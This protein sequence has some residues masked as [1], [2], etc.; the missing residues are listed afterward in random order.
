[1]STTRTS[2]S[3]RR[4]R[5]DSPWRTLGA[6]AALSSGRGKTADEDPPAAP[7]T[8]R[9][10]KVIRAWQAI[11]LLTFIA[12]VT[13][14]VTWTTVRI[15]TAAF[16]AKPGHPDAAGPLAY[17]APRVAGSLP[18]RDGAV[19]DAA[20]RAI[21]AEFK[22]RFIGAGLAKDERGIHVVR[23]AG[24]Y[25]EPGHIDPATGHPA[26]V[27][28]LGLSAAEPLRS[29]PATTISRLM[30]GL[31]GPGSLVGPWPALAGPRRGVAECTVAEL[32]QTP[33]AVC[34]WATASTAGAVISPVRDTSVAALARIMVAMR[35]NLEP[36]ATRPAPTRHATTKRA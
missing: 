28:Y 18:L 36:R 6:R 9:P 19:S 2:S 4:A 30:T 8:A 34:G 32:G 29:P 17:P 12:I 25:G 27:M 16:A 14:A 10:A 11:A 20:E 22:H 1:M 3:H 33:M 35:F 23:P 13:V 15:A 31:L 21:I 26:W 5:P 24:L 7:P